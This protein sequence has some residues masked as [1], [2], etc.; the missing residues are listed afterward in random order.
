VEFVA[1]SGACYADDV[2]V[3]IVGALPTPTAFADTCASA[4]GW[5][6]YDGGPASVVEAAVRIPPGTGVKTRSTFPAGPDVT[7]AVSAQI[8]CDEM[9]T[10][11]VRSAEF[12]DAG[13]WLHT[14]APIPSSSVSWQDWVEVT[15]TLAFPPDTQ[16]KASDVE[17]V[18]LGGEGFVR[19]VRVV[20]G[21]RLE[22]G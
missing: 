20:R 7:Y 3:S 14:Y 22:R 2:T 17:F 10:I 6:T 15:F 13:A 21:G 4:D 8:R 18:S 16:A 1:I 11:E 12:D 5:V 19:N 9:A